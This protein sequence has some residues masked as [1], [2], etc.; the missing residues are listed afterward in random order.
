MN[1]GSVE[2]KK[3]IIAILNNADLDPSTGACPVV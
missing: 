2:Q 3:D 1:P